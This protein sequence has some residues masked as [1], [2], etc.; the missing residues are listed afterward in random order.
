M[1]KLTIIALLFAT[2]LCK[3]QERKIIA[4]NYGGGNGRISFGKF[5]A[6]DGALLSTNSKSLNTFGFTYLN[7]TVKNL[8]L[9]T[10]INSFTYQ[11][12]LTA[13]GYGIDIPQVSNHKTSLIS[14]PIKL[15]YEV[16]KY[17]F[18]NGGLNTDIDISEKDRNSVSDF[19]GIGAGA[20][21]GL[22]YFKN[23]FGVYFNPQFD[24]R[25]LIQFTSSNQHNKILNSN[26]VFGLSYKMKQ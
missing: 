19:S 12:T 22:Q 8:F 1:K 23:H 13:V 15:R 6:Q 21:I 4:L 24:F 5:S 2:F 25:S 17:V 26:F 7:E 14:I 20:G 3:A 16:G 18:F 10:G 9:E 11:Y